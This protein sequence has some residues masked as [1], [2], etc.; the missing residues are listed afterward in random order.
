MKKMTKAIG[1][2]LVVAM[3]TT[4]FSVMSFAAE[5]ASIEIVKRPDR[6]VLYGELDTIGTDA[7]GDPTGM[8]LKVTDSDGLT[9]EI[10]CTYE[11]TV[12][13]IEDFRYG[14]NDGVV[15][16]GDLT[17]PI[18]LTVE[19][20]PIE[21][22]EITKM[23]AKTEYDWEKDVLTKNSSFDDYAAMFPEIL[24]ELLAEEDMTLEELKAFYE[25]NPDKWQEIISELLADDE[26][27]LVPNL[28]GME[29][30]V[31][32]YNGA[33]EVLTTDDDYSSY[34][35]YQFPIFVDAENAGF[36]EPGDNK[37]FI[38]V[39]GTET[40]FTLTVKKNAPVTPDVPVNPPKDDPKNPDIPNTVGSS[41]AI[42]AVVALISGCGIALIPSRKKK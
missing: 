23:P 1:V 11:N 40:P 10:E 28:T 33:V 30:T 7:Y 3:L 19:E 9:E 34:G 26:G 36:V 21:S 18:N 8:I 24:D 17:A 2:M 42:A 29:I 39:M 32:Y 20:N 13:L 14:P 27:I 38:Y 22:V 37:Y 31:K 6:I 4:V 12:I 35:G 25:A 16:Y 41:A 5:P 15:I